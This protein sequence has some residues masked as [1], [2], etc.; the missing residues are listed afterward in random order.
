MSNNCP[1][2]NVT[3]VVEAGLGK[4]AITML[5]GRS[6]LF[7]GNSS[8]FGMFTLALVY[9][10][11]SCVVM[12]LDDILKETSLTTFEPKVLVRLM[13]STWPG[14]LVSVVARFGIARPK[15]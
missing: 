2:P 10:P 8:L 15:N 14:T 7:C 9:C 5:G 6:E 11:A 1:A 3:A 12:S 4:L 13:A